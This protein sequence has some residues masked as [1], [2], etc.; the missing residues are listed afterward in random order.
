VSSL[1]R[2]DSY[3]THDDVGGFFFE[4]EAIRSAQARRVGSG[5]NKLESC[6]RGPKHSEMTPM[7][8]IKLQST[9]CKR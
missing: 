3:L 8:L 6:S 7:K 9:R 5:P 4:F 2:C 1:C